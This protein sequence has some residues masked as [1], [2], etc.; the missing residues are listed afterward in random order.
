VAQLSTFATASHAL[1]PQRFAVLD[2]AMQ[3]KEV[4][5]ATEQMLLCVSSLLS[6]VLDSQPARFQIC[7]YALRRHFQLGRQIESGE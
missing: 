4:D 3:K 5:D 6:S 2:F 1:L 7:V